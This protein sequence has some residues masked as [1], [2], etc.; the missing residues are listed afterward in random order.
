MAEA[1]R[2]AAFACLASWALLFFLRPCELGQVESARLSTPSKEIKIEMEIEIGIEIE[3]EI[4]IDIE[5][6]RR[7]T[8]RD[9]RRKQ[10]KRKREKV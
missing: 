3:I 8:D 6:H 1:G 4:K 2:L 10:E 5:T 9:N 7:H